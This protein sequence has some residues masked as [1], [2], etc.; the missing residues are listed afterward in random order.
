MIWDIIWALLEPPFVACLAWFFSRR[1]SVT[2]FWEWWWWVAAGVIVMAVI[3]HDVAAMVTA[4]VNAILAVFF[5]WRSRRRRDRAPRSYGAKTKAIL[6][7]IV[8]K[9][10]ESGKPR[11]ALR[12]QGIG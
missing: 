10:R 5:W 7:A 8:R 9:L 3:Y 2:L 6:T 12:P 1:R 4:A 11:P